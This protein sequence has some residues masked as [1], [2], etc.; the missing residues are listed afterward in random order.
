MFTGGVCQRRTVAAV[1]DW[2]SS[3]PF[4]DPARGLVEGRAGCA[5]LFKG[6]RGPSLPS[7]LL[8]AVRAAGASG[9]ARSPAEAAS[10]EL[11]AGRS[12]VVVPWVQGPAWCKR[13]VS[14]CQCAMGQEQRNG[15]CSS[16]GNVE[17]PLSPQDGGASPHPEVPGDA[18]RRMHRRFLGKWCRLHAARVLVLAALVALV[19]ALVLALAVVSGRCEGNA[20]LPVAQVLPCPDDWVGY[21]NVCYYLSREEGSWEWSQ[22]QCSSCGASLAVFKRDWEKEFL[23]RLK[24]NIDYWLGL[25]RQGERLQWVDGSSFND[26][27]LVQGQGP[28][29]FLN[30]RDLRSS[31]CSQHRPYLCSKPQALM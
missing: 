25:R 29:L 22:E 7:A 12:A 23:L 30:D 1:W 2:L 13:R 24:G 26:T 17:E 6:G 27:I 28:C 9:S 8:V 18:D 3:S 14:T 15:F 10:A 21:R 4:L 11:G 31:S 20:G 19:L 16:D 5:R